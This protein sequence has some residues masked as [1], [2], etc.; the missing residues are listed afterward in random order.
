MD[1]KS[2]MKN[3][4]HYILQ[5]KPELVTNEFLTIVETIMH[6]NDSNIF[7]VIQ[8]FILHVSK[9]LIKQSEGNKRTYGKN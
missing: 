7:H 6:S 1:K 2:I 8:Y 3:Y 9:Y 4:F 5:K